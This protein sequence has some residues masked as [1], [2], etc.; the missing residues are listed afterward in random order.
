MACYGVLLKATGIWHSFGT[1]SRI[2]GY[3]KMAFSYKCP[4]CGTAFVYT[5]KNELGKGAG[6]CGHECLNPECDVFMNW[7]DPDMSGQPEACTHAYPLKQRR[8]Q[9][10]IKSD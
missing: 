2:G 3:L 1:K 4:K 7:D 8:S 6:H 9:L 10:P 5:P